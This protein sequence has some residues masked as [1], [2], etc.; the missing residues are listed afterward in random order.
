MAEK[1][2]YLKRTWAEISLDRLA[3][4]FRRIRAGVA[5]GVKIMSVVKADA[6]GHG[7]T[8]VAPELQR[9]GSDA[10][11]VS[12]I[13][14]AVVLRRSG[15]TRPILVLGWVPPAWADVLLREQVETAVFSL[16]SAAVL[17]EEAGK[18]GG[19]VSVHLKVDTGMGRL[20]IRASDEAS[21]EAAIAEIA[22]I[23]QL[24]NLRI[25]GLFTHFSTAD[26]TESPL[27]ARQ[28]KLFTELRKGLSERGIEIETCHCANSAAAALHP[29][30]ACDMV[31]AGV[32]LYG[33]SP[34]NSPEGSLAAVCGGEPVMTLK[35][36]VVQRR[37]FFAGD[38][39]SYGAK[40]LERD[41]EIAVIPVG[42]ADGYPR[43]LSNCGSVGIGGKQAPIVGKV[44]MDMTMIDVSG[45]DADV[46][47]EV[48][49]FGKTTDAWIPAETV[50][51]AAGTIGY[52][53]V[54]CIGRR[55]ARVYIKDQNEIHSVRLT[56]A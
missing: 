6:Y 4:N 24:P 14:E 56:T 33:L 16:E 27:T 51:E 23:A 48:L 3:Q 55:V 1:H 29:E 35:T 44:C 40:T 45:I 42:Y 10:F 54:C 15:I 22:E 11:A 25:V 46:G 39:V 52:E 53:L 36:T 43:L 20:G 18:A 13:E 28:F 31:R 21:L 17:S 38:T 41:A 50:A 47:S 9:L 49:L 2:S 12:N 8:V 26:E 19:I 37:Q 32:S 5:D 7:A 34:D 30:Y